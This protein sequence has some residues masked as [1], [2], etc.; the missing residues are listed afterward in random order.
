MSVW[1]VIV[2]Y[3]KLRLSGFEAA[4]DYILGLLNDFLSRDDVAENVEKGYRL[5]TSIVSWMERLRKYCPEPWAKY[6]ESVY[7]CVVA[8]AD[9]FKDGKI[10][11]AELNA[12]RDSFNGAYDEWH[13]E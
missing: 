3:L 2:T 1:N 13:K 5:A 8:V 9:M 4:A 7:G 6:Y 10:D 11:L 12:V